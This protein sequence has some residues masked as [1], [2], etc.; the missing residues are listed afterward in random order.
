MKI[1]FY[2]NGGYEPILSNLAK[3]LIDYDIFAFCQNNL[4]Y[5]SAL[6]SS[7]YKEKKYLYSDFNRKYNA[8]PEIDN[9]EYLI[10]LYVALST[11]KSHF[12]KKSSYYQE[13][14]SKVM[15][16][17]FE[18]WINDLKP[19]FIFFPII[20]SIDSMILYQLCISLNVTPICYGHGRHINR[21]FF[22]EKFTESLPFYYK[23][24]P[25]DKKDISN[26]EV[27]LNNY[28]TKKKS[29]TYS[30]F[31]E[32]SFEESVTFDVEN[33]FFRFLR[34]L[35]LSFTIEKHNQTLSLRVKFLV[36]VEKLLVP[37][38]RRI[39]R[40][41]EYLYIRPIKDLPQNFDLFPLHFSPESSI[42]TPSPYFIDQL[43][44]IEHIKFFESS[45]NKILLL[46]E[47]PAMYMRRPFSFYRKIHKMPFVRFVPSNTKIVGLIEN[48]D[49]IYSVT[50]TAALEAYFLRKEWRLLGKNFLSEWIQDN[51]N[52][53]GDPLLFISDVFKVSANFI[54]FSPTLK[55][56]KLNN[57]LFSKNNISEMANHFRFHINNTLK[58]R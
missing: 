24:I 37:L 47:H 56:R 17:I 33:V 32:T 25:L 14:V 30:D 48:A 1:A 49:K 7:I 44:A 12:K 8:F 20:E 11:D 38:E 52:I 18:E 41:F 9:K 57:A 15:Y 55:N 45:Q 2:I 51:K 54:L 40:I 22:T 42:N 19:D 39:F 29:L 46:K 10:D 35:I 36:F 3:E 16:C 26:A 6:S 43:R 4:A 50:G 34:N 28:L 13:K 58:Y 27:F 23:F 53:N 31:F 21:S 5:R